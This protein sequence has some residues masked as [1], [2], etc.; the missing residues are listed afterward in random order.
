MQGGLWP[1][2]NS[3]WR[4][5]FLPFKLAVG[6][7]LATGGGCG[8]MGMTREG[9]FEYLGS[10]GI[11]TLTIDH[12]AVFTVKESN[13]VPVALRGAFTKNLFLKDEDGTLLLV[14]AKSTAKIDLKRLGKRLGIGRLSFGKP[15]LLMDVLGVSP[16]SVTAFAIVN[17]QRQRVRVVLDDQLL[18]HD[19]VNCHPLENTATTN[20]ALADLLRF[21]RATGHEPTTMTLAAGEP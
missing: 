21:I 12:P 11:A 2:S 8:L 14:V 9:L 16:G 19:S 13:E 1:P 7:D 4:R 10:L 17:D 6:G 3:P 18:A 15:E 20:I 5:G